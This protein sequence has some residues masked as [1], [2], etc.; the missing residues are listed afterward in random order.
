VA[1]EFDGLGQRFRRA[2]PLR[3]WVLT[4]LRTLAAL[5][6]QS[7]SSSLAMLNPPGRRFGPLQVV[8]KAVMY[9]LNV[10]LWASGVL[11]A[12]SAAPRGL[13]VLVCV[14][15][16]AIAFFFVAVF[17]YAEARYL[18]PGYPLFYVALGRLLAGA[19][20]RAVP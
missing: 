9:A 11:F 19:G 14:F 7:F 3:Y 12:F 2:A 16:W 17:R 6:F 8:A 20:P 15:P 4:P 10:A 13:K 5:V 1:G 18:L